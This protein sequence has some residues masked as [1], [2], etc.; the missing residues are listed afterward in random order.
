MHFMKQFICEGEQHI[1]HR[2]RHLRKYNQ[3][4]LDLRN[5]AVHSLA[6]FEL[7]CKC[8]TLLS[9]HEGRI[10]IKID[11]E[12][13]RVGIE[14]ASVVVWKRKKMRHSDTLFDS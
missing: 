11:A 7:E 3:I 13:C 1:I 2:T 9:V 10:H 5:F 14:L 12:L 6:S 4:K 8:H